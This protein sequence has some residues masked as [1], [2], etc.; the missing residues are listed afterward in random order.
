MEVEEHGLYIIKDSYFEEYP[1][2]GWM[3]NKNES[4][5][6]YYAIKDKAGVFW[7][8]P[9][10]SKVDNY[11]EKISRVEAQRGAGNCLYYEIGQIAG[12]ERAFIISS[13]LPVTEDYISHPYT[14]N[15]QHYVVRN[16]RLIRSLYSKSMRYL[17]LLE[18]GVMKDQNHVLYI[19]N[20]L[21]S[22]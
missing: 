20:Q 15:K 9:M 6:H 21:V 11:R 3:W 10:S 14:I 1:G 8:I 18:Q 12:R 4:R 19:R 22:R 17:K 2:H 7:M 16:E 13:M 5:P